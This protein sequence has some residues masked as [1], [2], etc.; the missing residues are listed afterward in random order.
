MSLKEKL[1]EKME[2]PW[3]GCTKAEMILY[4]RT[5][6]KTFRAWMNRRFQ[7]DEKRSYLCNSNFK[8]FNPEEK[9]VILKE[10]GG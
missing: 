4:L 7:N 3:Q 2:D 1:K 9:K 8:I 6:K 10:L 5:T